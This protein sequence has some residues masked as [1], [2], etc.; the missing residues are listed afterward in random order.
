[1]F[2]ASPFFFAPHGLVDPGD[3]GDPVYDRALWLKGDAL[4]DASA[5]GAT[6]TPIRSVSLG[7]VGGEGAIVFVPTSDFEAAFLDCR[8]AGLSVTGAPFTVRARVRFSKFGTGYPQTIISNYDGQAF[9]RF[10]FGVSPSGKLMYLDQGVNG[11]DTVT[12]YGAQLSVDTWY[13][14]A[15]TK[16]GTEVK[17]YVSGSLSA[18]NTVY[19]TQYPDMYTVG[20]FADGGQW[21][22]P[23]YGA[24]ASLEVIKGQA[25]AP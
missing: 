25:I 8:A 14:V 20:A 15:V 2:T 1:M 7:S 9:G 24:I 3:P 10:C 19:I 23:L 18:S 6:V 5:Y 4:S 17:L 12:I 13:D 22:Y 16:S 11:S 21:A